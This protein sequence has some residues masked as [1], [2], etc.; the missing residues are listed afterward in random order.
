MVAGTFVLA[1]EEPRKPLVF[2]FCELVADFNKIISH[3]TAHFRVTQPIRAKWG[4]REGA[5]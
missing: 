4:G 1:P 3:T 2:W 5:T